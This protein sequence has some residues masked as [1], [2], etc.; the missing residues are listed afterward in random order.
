MQLE[1]VFDEGDE[2]QAIYFILAGRVLICPQGQ[3]QAPIATLE[4]P[5]PRHLRITRRGS[6]AGRDNAKKRA[7]ATR[8]VKVHAVS[9]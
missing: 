9:A 5:D 4:R 1:E 2:G 7:S 6:K 3:P 8:R